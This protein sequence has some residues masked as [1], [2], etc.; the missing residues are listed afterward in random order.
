MSHYLNSFIWMFYLE[1]YTGNI[2]RVVNGDTRSLDF[3][4]YEDR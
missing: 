4:S 1:E 3:S 2:L